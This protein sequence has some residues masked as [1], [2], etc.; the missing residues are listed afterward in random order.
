MEQKVLESSASLVSAFSN[1]LADAV[2]KISGALVQVNG[3]SRQSASGIV[4][5]NELVL[6]ADHVL[7]R[8]EDLTIQTPDKRTLPAQFVGRD[9]ATDLA[10]LRVPGLNIQPALAAGQPARVGQLILAVG[11]PGS[12][13]P[14]A[15]IGIVSSIGGPLRTR[16]GVT[17]EK[18]IQT[19]AIP[20]PGFSGGPLIDPQ[21]TVV[22]VM[23]TGLVS[24]VA[25]GIPV[26]HAWRTANTLAQQGYIKRG[27]LGISSQPVQLAPE[28]RGGHNQERG[29]M[30]VRVEDNS[31][32]HQGGILLGDILL[33]IDG[34]SVTAAEDFQSI[35][36]G[37]RVGKTVQ[38]E[39]IRG[40]T[41]Q[42]LNVT[43]GQRS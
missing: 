12:D 19:D 13:G 5:G 17:L 42:T 14:M 33:T 25:L 31:P 32:A 40:G 4:F 8:E 7:E 39:V 37:E 28:Q 10:V 34:Q 1:Q 3:R 18:F 35:L 2:E 43:I 24:S 6:T 41:L 9:I 15:S 23:T 16:Q 26:E 38:V 22:G 21:G 27:Y 30:I 20:Y 36:G 11:R 29:L